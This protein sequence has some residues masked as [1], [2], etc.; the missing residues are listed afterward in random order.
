MPDPVGQRPLVTATVKACAQRRLRVVVLAGA[1][2][3]EGRAPRWRSCSANGSSPSR[4]SRGEEKQASRRCGNWRP[5]FFPAPRR[6]ATCGPAARATVGAGGVRIEPRQQRQ[7]TEIAD[8]QLDELR[9]SAARFVPRLGKMRDAIDEVADRPCPLRR[10]GTDPQRQ[11][12]GAARAVAAGHVAA[13]GQFEAELVLDNLESGKLADEL[14]IDRI[15]DEELQHL[16]DV[17]Q[18]PEIVSGPSPACATGA[19]RRPAGAA[20]RS[21]WPA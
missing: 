8:Q 1:A 2:R 10:A 9:R 4:W 11:N 20:P 12:V 13:V 17:A 5:R 3:A 14:R 15:A 19:D 16:A 7:R 6:T 18:R 21:G